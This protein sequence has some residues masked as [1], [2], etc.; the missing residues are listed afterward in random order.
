MQELEEQAK[1]AKKAEAA[2]AK[3]AAW[4]A[5]NAARKERNRLQKEE[6]EGAERGRMCSPPDTATPNSKESSSDSSVLLFSIVGV[7]S[8][9][10]VDGDGEVDGSISSSTPQSR[11]PTDSWN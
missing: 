11:K 10:S 4:A 5:E 7:G 3:E 6:E 8:L 2:R 1:R 9:Y